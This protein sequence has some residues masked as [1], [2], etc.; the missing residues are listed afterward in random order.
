MNGIPHEGWVGHALPRD[1]F[2]FMISE[3][4]NVNL[5][6]GCSQRTVTHNNILSLVSSIIFIN[7][8]FPTIINEFSSIY[9]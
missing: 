3:S 6:W 8:N 2:F 7:M 5:I 1:R 9:H 4:L